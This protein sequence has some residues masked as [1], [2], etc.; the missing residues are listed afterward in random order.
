MPSPQQPAA[1]KPSGEPEKTPKPTTS[2]KAPR[3]E[4]TVPLMLKQEYG[5]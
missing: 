3:R 2:W 4:R 5:R 1:A